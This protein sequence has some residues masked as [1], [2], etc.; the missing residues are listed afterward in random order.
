MLPRLPDIPIQ[1]TPPT[2]CRTKALKKQAKALEKE[3]VA[4]LAEDGEEYDRK[5]AK[6]EAKKGGPAIAAPEKV[7]I[8]NAPAQAPAGLSIKLRKNK[9]KSAMVVQDPGTPLTPVAA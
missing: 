4:K 9:Q 7:T 3:R 5:K 1:H 2:H 8:S 6:A